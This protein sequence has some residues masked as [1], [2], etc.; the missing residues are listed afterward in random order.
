M[1]GHARSTSSRRC[2]A[3]WSEAFQRVLTRA[4]VMCDVPFCHAHTSSRSASSRRCAATASKSRPTGSARRSS[5]KAG[6]RAAT[7]R[8]RRECAHC[9]APCLSDA[10]HVHPGVKPAARDHGRRVTRLRVRFQG[11]HM[12]SFSSCTLVVRHFANALRAGQWPPPVR[13]RFFWNMTGVWI[14]HRNNLGLRPAVHN[15]CSSDRARCTPTPTPSP[16]NSNN[17]RAW[18]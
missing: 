13:A 15:L 11:P 18:W 5:T 7:A 6:A 12:L 1:P 10:D 14:Q 3:A 17:K 4:H 2:A 8:R 16:N 9:P